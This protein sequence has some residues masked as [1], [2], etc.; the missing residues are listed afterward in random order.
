M[1]QPMVSPRLLKTL[2]DGRLESLEL[3]CVWPEVHQALDALSAGHRAYLEG[4]RVVELSRSCQGLIGVLNCGFD[5]DP[6]ATVLRDRPR[7]HRRRGGRIVY[8]LHGQCDPDGP[9]EVY[10]RTAAKARPVAIKSLLNTL[11]HEWVHHFDFCRWGESVHC[12]GFYERLGQI[13]RP[14]RDELG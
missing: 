10:T 2:D 9:I 7:P 13:Y 3:L 5:I 1:S 14:A 11:L 8:E 4:G 6:K 12:S